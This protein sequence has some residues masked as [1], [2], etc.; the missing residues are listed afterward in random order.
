MAHF[1]QQVLG[2]QFRVALINQPKIGIGPSFER[3]VHVGVRRCDAGPQGL[4]Q[5]GGTTVAIQEFLGLS[6]ED[7]L[8]LLGTVP[9][10]GEWGRPR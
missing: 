6:L 1:G 2:Q 8:E 10:H 5:P 9:R 4:S 7:Y 3:A